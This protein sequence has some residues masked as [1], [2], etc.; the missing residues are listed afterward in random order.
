MSFN[1]V[2]NNSFIYGFK[3]FSVPV[4]AELLQKPMNHAQSTAYYL[5]GKSRFVVSIPG[6]L[7]DIVMQILQCIAFIFENLTVKAQLLLGAKNV[8]ETY[9][10]KNVYPLT[11]L[12]M[13]LRKITTL[14]EPWVM[15]ED[16][17][18]ADY[19]K[20]NSVLKSEGLI[21]FKFANYVVQ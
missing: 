7:I 8:K 1:F 14:N 21:F 18:I 19:F 2:T 6:T 5:G 16:L 9:A 4:T 13:N 10:I 15:A 20:C 17:G 11:S 3:K 12:F